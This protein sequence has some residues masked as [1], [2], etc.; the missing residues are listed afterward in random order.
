MDNC[1]WI[2]TQSVMYGVGLNVSFKFVQPATNRTCQ[3]S[4]SEVCIFLF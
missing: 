3:L 2:D 4:V 1:S